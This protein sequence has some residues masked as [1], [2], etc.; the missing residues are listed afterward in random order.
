MFIK[1]VCKK[2]VFCYSATPTDAP[3]TIDPICPPTTGNEVIY[4]PN[5]DD[6]SKYWECSNGDRV[7]QQC[8]PGL[9]WNE[10]VNSCDFPYNVNCTATSMLIKWWFKI[11]VMWW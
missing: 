11:E 7:A 1:I 5:P 10:A 6:C 9:Y 2:S 4:V 3:G 8:S